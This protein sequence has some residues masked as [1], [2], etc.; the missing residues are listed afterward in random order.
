ML[1][2]CYIAVIKFLVY[3]LVSIYSDG[4]RDNSRSS[5]DTASSVESSPCTGTTLLSTGFSKDDE[6]GQLLCPHAMMARALSMS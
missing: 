1:S 2:F 4:S 3:V 5:T 6:S